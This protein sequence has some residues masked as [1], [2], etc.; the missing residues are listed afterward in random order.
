MYQPLLCQPEFVPHIT[1]VP[2]APVIDK[3]SLVQSPIWPPVVD[4][5]SPA[6]VVVTA[7]PVTGPARTK[8]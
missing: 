7:V 4:T 5:K 8:V 6:P 2:G 1:G 3:V